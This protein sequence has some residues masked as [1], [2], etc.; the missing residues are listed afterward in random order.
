MENILEKF[1]SYYGDEKENV[2]HF[3]GEMTPKK[4]KIIE[5]I[6]GPDQLGKN[7]E[8]VLPTGES[9][10]KTFIL[11][12]EN[13]GELLE[14]LEIRLNDELLSKLIREIEPEQK[15]NGQGIFTLYSLY[16]SKK[17]TEI[18]SKVNQ[19]TDERKRYIVFM[20]LAALIKK[21]KVSIDDINLMACNDKEGIVIESKLQDG[22][23]LIASDSP[24]TDEFRPFGDFVTCIFDERVD[25]GVVESEESSE[26]IF[27]SKMSGHIYKHREDE[28]VDF[29][30]TSFSYIDVG[31]VAEEEYKNN[32]KNYY[33]IGR[34]IEGKMGEL[35][36]EPEV[37]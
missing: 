16:N 13:R 34:L 27:S 19:I 9:L 15:K 7:S 25:K 20:T 8:E 2:R 32:N 18:V 37:R 10:D 1:L 35:F 31:D 17:S 14:Q 29:K 23:F 4:L 12:L 28:G 36:E 24:S 11:D 6:K 30:S 21:G 33:R 26:R 5:Q 22:R 3:L